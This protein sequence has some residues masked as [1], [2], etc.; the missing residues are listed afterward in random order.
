MLHPLKKIVDSI[1]EYL[2]EVTLKLAP[3]GIYRKRDS[4]MQR[5]R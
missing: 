1:S 2:S 4:P 3:I 5:S